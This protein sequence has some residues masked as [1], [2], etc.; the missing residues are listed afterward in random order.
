QNTRRWTKEEHNLF[1]RGLDLHG[2]DW[3]HI[4]SLVGT[5]TV[6][7]TRTHAHKHFR[8]IENA[9]LNGD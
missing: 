4:A 5:R 6:K 9:Q 1:L 2:R 3:K 7:Q 8:N